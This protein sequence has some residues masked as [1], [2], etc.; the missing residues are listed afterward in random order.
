VH[1]WRVLRG[2][3][4]CDNAECP[5][6]DRRLRHRDVD[7]ARLLLR[8][9]LVIDATGAPLPFLRHVNHHDEPPGEFLLLPL[10]HDFAASAR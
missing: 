7:A 3:Q 6:P 10:G 2:A 1:A 9:V 4:Y 8:G 5:R